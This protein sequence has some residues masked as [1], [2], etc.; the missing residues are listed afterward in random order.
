MKRVLLWLILMSIGSSACAC[1]LVA[2]GNV[3]VA[4]PLLVQHSGCGDIAAQVLVAPVVQPVVVVQRRSFMTRFGAR[5]S[6][7]RGVQVS[8]R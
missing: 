4:V 5:F 6:T 1:D 7:R 2:T 3:A 8:V